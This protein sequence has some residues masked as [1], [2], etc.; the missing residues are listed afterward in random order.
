MFSVVVLFQMKF[1]L[2]ILPAS[3]KLKGNKKNNSLAL[4]SVCLGCKSL[5]SQGRL[6]GVGVSTPNSCV[7]QGSAVI[8]LQA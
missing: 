3:A 8:G 6:E 2:R 5:K 4:G 1:L 7:V